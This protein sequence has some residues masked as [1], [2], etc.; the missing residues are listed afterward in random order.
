MAHPLRQPIETHVDRLGLLRANRRSRK[1]KKLEKESVVCPQTALF[2]GNLDGRYR[3]QI[4]QGTDSKT[5][6]RQGTRL[7]HEVLKKAAVRT[8]WV[9]SPVH[10]P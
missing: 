9:E 7:G 3:S 1:T 4:T 6:K 8:T 10:L 5:R 2:L